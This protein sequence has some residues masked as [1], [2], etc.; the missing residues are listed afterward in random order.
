[1]NLVLSGIT[2]DLLGIRFE[3]HIRSLQTLTRRGHFRVVKYFH[4]KMVQ[5]R[6]SAGR[7]EQ[8]QF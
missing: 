8:H 7:L 1:L 3:R 6:W 2:A 5:P 4:T